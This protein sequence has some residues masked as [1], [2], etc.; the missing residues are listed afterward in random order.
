MSTALSGPGP[1]SSAPAPTAA[2]LASSAP[3]SSPALLAMAPF[4]HWGVVGVDLGRVWGLCEKEV[5][6]RGG[7]LVGCVV[8]VAVD[9][10]RLRD[11]CLS[12]GADSLGARLASAFASRPLPRGGLLTFPLA[13]MM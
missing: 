9:V 7:R 10:V 6:V 12:R 8:V 4:G 5:L 1:P 13:E 3:S 2:V 11:K